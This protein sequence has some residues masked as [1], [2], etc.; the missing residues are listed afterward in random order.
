MRPLREDRPQLCHDSGKT[1]KRDMNSAA[2]IGLRVLRISEGGSIV[3]S[4][5]RSLLRD[6]VRHHAR[7]RQQQLHTSASTSRS[8]IAG[9][10]HQSGC[11]SSCVSSRARWHGHGGSSSG[12]SRSSGGRRGYQQSSSSS[13]SIP[14]TT[15]W[16]LIPLSLSK[17]KLDDSNHDNATLIDKAQDFYEHAKD[18]SLHEK[19]SLLEEG[20]QLS[21]WDRFL[22]SIHRYIIEPLGTARRFLY[23]AILFIPVIVTAPLLALELSNDKTSPSLSKKKQQRK[24]HERATTRWWYNF[25]VKQMERAGPT[26]IKVSTEDLASLW[27]FPLLNRI[28][29]ASFNSLLNGRAHAE[30][31]SPMSSVIC[32]QDCIRMARR[33]R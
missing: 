10:G 20:E 33:I 18:M 19:S 26:F 12:S 23:L 7:H 13:S 25:L 16:L 24:Y 29:R 4:C 30:I 3:P 21:L 32:L 1:K 5:S 2:S 8:T 27:S 14:R 15:A 31:S 22:T 9:T 6:A 11:S 17:M 28:S